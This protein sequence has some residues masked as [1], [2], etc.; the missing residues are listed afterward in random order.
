MR[1]TR[2]ALRKGTARPDVVGLVSDDPQVR[3]RAARSVC[4]CKVGFDVY[5]QHIDELARL[6]K[7]EDPVVRFNALHVREDAELMEFHD[8]RKQRA[9]H[10]EERR[11]QRADA[12]RAVRQRR[13][14][15]R[16]T[17]I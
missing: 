7:D 3:G 15:R 4:P 12:K 13:A 6:R 14:R 11:A 17:A 10:A 9:A 8:D 16:V 1:Q 5:E 2:K